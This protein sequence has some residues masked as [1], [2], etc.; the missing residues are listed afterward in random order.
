[1]PIWNV[2]EDQNN[3]PHNYEGDAEQ[4]FHQKEARRYEGPKYLVSNKT[5]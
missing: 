4:G 2:S 1:M 3:E 5:L